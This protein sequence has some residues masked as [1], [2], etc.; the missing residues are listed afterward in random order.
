MS[1][2]TVIL[3]LLVIFVGIPLF[4]C[5]LSTLYLR[6]FLE[7]MHELETMGE[8][9]FALLPF[10]NFPFFVRLLLNRVRK[11]TLDAHFIELASFRRPNSG[12]I[13]FATTLASDDGKI[14]AEI[15]YARLPFLPTFLLI[16]VAPRDFLRCLVGLHG[17]CITTV[18]SNGRRVMT[19][20]MAFLAHDAV[21]GEKEFLVVPRHLSVSDMIDSHRKSIEQISRETGLNPKLFRDA[22]DVFQ[23]ELEVLRKLAASGREEVEQAI[24]QSHCH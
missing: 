5:A 8:G 4:I 6:R 16:F 3:W 12:H 11:E 21:E 7:Q 17:I 1:F 2:F 15:E 24:R 14:I 20:K 23:F 13:D 10:E 22:Q 9:D 19:T 18:F